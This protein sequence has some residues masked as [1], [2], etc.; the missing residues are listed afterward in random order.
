MGATP[1]G[2]IIEPGSALKFQTGDWRSFRPIHDK[3]KCTSCML[4]WM[5]CPDDTI[6]VK[7]GQ[8]DGIMMTHCKGCGI[9]AKHCPKKAF[10][11][12]QE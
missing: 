9:C 6:L 12:V 1:G 5:Y 3:A 8:M 11:M 2:R 4:C 10:T 7:D